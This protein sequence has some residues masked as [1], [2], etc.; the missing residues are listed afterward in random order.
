MVSTSRKITLLYFTT[1]T[2]LVVVLRLPS[3]NLLLDTDSS[4]NAFF[5]RQML[6]G[7]ILYD[8][9]HPAHHLPGIYYTF[10][11]AF[12]LFGDNPVAPKLL[13]VVFMFASTWFL[14]LIGSTLFNDFV[15][16]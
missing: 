5:A 7:E 13:L 11:L 8:R 9:F 10:V 4:V 2:L 1:L 6:R 3:L 15:G 14:F 16:M 12:K